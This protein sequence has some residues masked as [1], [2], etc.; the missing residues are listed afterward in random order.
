MSRARPS[1]TPPASEA[2]A[3]NPIDVLHRLLKLGNRLGAPFSE[4]LE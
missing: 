3:V 2:P 4:H 1:K